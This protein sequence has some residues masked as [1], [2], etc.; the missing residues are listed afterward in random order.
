MSIIAGLQIAMYFLINIIIYFITVDI[1]FQLQTTKF[2]YGCAVNAPILK[3]KWLADSVAAGSVV[4][5][6]K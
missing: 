3:V 2:L 5:P 6:E 4:P 1:F